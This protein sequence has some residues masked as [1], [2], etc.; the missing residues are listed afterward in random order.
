MNSKFWKI[1]TIAG[2][3]LAILSTGT[4]LVLRFN[5]LER[6]TLIVDSFSKGIRQTQE[7]LAGTTQETQQENSVMSNEDNKIF[8]KMVASCSSAEECVSSLNNP[9]F[10]NV[11][12]SSKFLNDDDLVIGVSF[13][14]PE[15]EDDPVKAYPVKI[16]EHYEVI[17][18]FVNEMP[19]VVTYSPLT[20]APRVYDRLIDGKAEVFTVSHFVLNSSPVLY[21]SSTKS[22]WNQ[23]DGKALTDEY[24]H[25]KL[26]PHSSVLMR[27]SDWVSLYPQTVVLTAP[28]VTQLSSAFTDYSE[29]DRIYFPVENADSRLDPKTVVYSLS[30]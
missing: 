8:Q 5:I 24:R 25:R 20:M 7:V 2:L 30:F 27:W 21:D 11:R 19:V 3:F 26:V 18:D 29:D 10:V 6:F 22:M 12:E 1:L 23:F 9:Q 28:N 14:H 17:N 13:E 16:M 4:I 15:I